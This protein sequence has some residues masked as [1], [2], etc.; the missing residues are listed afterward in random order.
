MTGS[1]IS[2]RRP[3]PT[4]R[5]PA[6]ALVM[7]LLLIVMLVAATGRMATTVATGSI[8]S[9]ARANTL[10]HQLAVDSTI[11]LVA[12]QLQAG[13]D[14]AHDLRLDGGVILAYRFGECHARCQVVS[15][16]GKFSIRAFARSED[17]PLLRKKLQRIRQRLDLPAARIRLRPVRDGRFEAAD[18]RRISLPAYASYDQLFAKRSMDAVFGLG[19]SQDADQSGAA[20]SWSDAVTLHGDGRVDLRY[21]APEILR[22]L[23]EEVDPRA[24]NQ[25]L[26]YREQA[27]PRLNLATA[28]AQVPEAKRDQIR[29]RIGLDIDRY[30]LTIDTII[31]NDRRRW[32]VVAD[33]RGGELTKL[34]HRGRI[35]W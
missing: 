8:R 1:R 14:T 31:R 17:R 23:L 9:N 34:H 3:V 2:D 19:E 7:T 15:D 30:A 25:L 16:A 5:R 26:Q 27:G 21:V 32:Y 22:V 10:Q 18:G 11:R 28:L 33:I 24:A 20:T 35:T 29:R 6:L 4:P 13:T 12:D